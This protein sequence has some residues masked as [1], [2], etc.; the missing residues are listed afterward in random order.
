MILVG[1][2]GGNQ[3]GMKEVAEMLNKRWGGTTTVVHYI[4]EYYESMK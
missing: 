2:S 4:P 3:N 1:D